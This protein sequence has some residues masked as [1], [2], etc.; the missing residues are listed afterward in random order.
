MAIAFIMLLAGVSEA[1][2]YKLKPS[3]PTFKN[4]SGGTIQYTDVNTAYT[5]DSGSWGASRQYDTAFVDCDGTITTVWEWVPDKIPG[6]STDDDLDTPPEWVIVHEQGEASYSGWYFLSGMG[7]G[8]CDNDLGFEVDETLAPWYMQGE[9]PTLIGYTFSG[10]AKGTRYKKQAGGAEITVTCSPFAGVAVID[11]MCSAKVSYGVQIINP[12]VEVLGATDFTTPARA[13]KFIT[14]QNIG[15][16]LS[17]QR[18]LG[19]QLYEEQHLGILQNSHS[20]TIPE[21]D[22]F[23]SYTYGSIGKR[24]NHSADDL[25]LVTLEFYSNANGSGQVTCSFKVTQPTGVK[26]EG[27]L[28]DATAKSK[29]IES[30][31]PD[32]VEWHIADGTVTGFFPDLFSFFTDGNADYGQHW[33]DVEYSLSGGFGQVGQGAFCQLITPERHVF[34]TVS[35]T[36]PP[37]DFVLLNPNT[38]QGANGIQARDHVFPYAVGPAPLWTISGKG[39]AG[40][41]PS[42]PTSVPNQNLNWTKSTAH[43]TFEAWA[44]YKPPQK[45]DRTTTW[46]PMAK[47]TWQWRGTAT[48]TAN[49]WNLTGTTPSG[50]TSPRVTTNIHP[51]WDAVLASPF[52][53]WGVP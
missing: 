8:D 30:V 40:D 18:S 28:P 10:I 9:E 19:N 53:S 13:I 20:W 2:Q 52:T 27:G 47:Y 21:W 7:L 32:F 3:T 14:G 44:M 34:G 41:N 24:H 26:F 16:T 11:G 43:D 6:T 31:R 5:G 38:G 39:E 23:K 4:P 22:P 33:Y 37:I 35:S 12:K 15:A 17:L 36:S 49:G 1:G 45:G 29:Q 48:N 51:E 46:I 50:L 25:K 42:Q